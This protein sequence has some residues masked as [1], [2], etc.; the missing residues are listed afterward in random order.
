MRW[1]INKLYNWNNSRYSNKKRNHPKRDFC[2]HDAK[3]IINIDKDIVS[4]ISRDELLVKLAQELGPNGFND[5]F[6]ETFNK[7][8]PYIYTKG[9]IGRF[10]SKQF[11]VNKNL[12]KGDEDE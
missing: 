3:D 6:K 1:V 11:V 5:W 10:K 9:S 4:F 2:Y 12:L 8:A 7:P